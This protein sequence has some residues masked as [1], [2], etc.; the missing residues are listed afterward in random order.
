ARRHCFTEYGERPAFSEQARP[1]VPLSAD[2]AAAPCSVRLSGKGSRAC[3]PGPRSR[4]AACLTPPAAR[5]VWAARPA[6]P[7]PART[8]AALP[9]VGRPGAHYLAHDRELADLLG[10]MVGHQQDRAQ[11][12]LAAAGRDGALQVGPGVLDDPC[13]VRAILLKRRNRAP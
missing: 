11:D 8:P 2:I 7:G 5:G 12:R 13:Q 3:A 6:A 10:V 4:R 1:R 9:M